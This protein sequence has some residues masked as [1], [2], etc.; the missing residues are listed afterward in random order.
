MT[1]RAYRF[2]IVFLVAIILGGGFAAFG[3]CNDQVEQ[4][5]KVTAMK[6]EY[7]PNEITVKKGVP[8]T[9]EFT[10]LDRPHGFSCP[11]LAIRTDII[12]EKVNRVHFVPLKTGAFEFHCDLFCGEGHENMTGKI[13]VTE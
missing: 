1:K 3:N 4:V 7:S 6:F 9:L 2:A 10:S 11:D 8:V 12:P 13:I 5:I